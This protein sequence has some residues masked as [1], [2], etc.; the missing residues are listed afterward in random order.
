MSSELI[1]SALCLII[2]ALVIAIALIE[3]ERRHWKSQYESL[4]NVTLTEGQAHTQSAIRVL[5]SLNTHP[6]MT[7]DEFIDSQG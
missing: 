2:L 1:I 4:R 7:L 3:S 6:Q 5:D